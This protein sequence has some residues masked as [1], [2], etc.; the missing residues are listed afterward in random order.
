LKAK[1]GPSVIDQIEFDVAAPSVELEFPFTLAVGQRLS[2]AQNGKVGLDVVIPD[3]PQKVKTVV[4][5]AFIEIIEKEPA[6]TPCFISVFEEKVV[7]TPAFESWVKL[8]T[9]G[10]AGSA[11]RLMPGDRIVLKRVVGREVKASAKPPDRRLVVLFGEKK[12]DI[13]VRGR[14]KR[15]Q[16]MNDKGDAHSLKAAPLELWT[17][18]GG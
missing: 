6:D 18:G 11:C 13:R 10:L 14:N 3:T 16:G 17:M 8:I 7:V 1:Q 15:V 4:K 2:G 5:T 9:K 12:A